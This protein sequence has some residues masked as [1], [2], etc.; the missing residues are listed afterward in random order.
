[1]MISKLPSQLLMVL[2]L[3]GF[4]LL[5]TAAPKAELW[6]IWDDSDEES[7]ESIDH[8]P[9]Q[10]LLQAYLISDHPSGVNRFDYAA[11]SDADSAR[12]EQYLDALQELDPRDYNRAEQ[13][14]YWINLYNALTVALILDEYPVKSILKVGEGVFNFFGPWDDV[15]AEVAGESLTLNDIEHRIL[16][17]IWQDSRI[18]FAVN[19]ASI[20]CPDL[21]PV[22][23]TA[24][25]SE[26]LLSQGAR[27]YLS[28]PRGAHF[29]AKQRLVLSEIF[30]WYGVDFGDSEQAVIAA[31]SQYAP[32]ELGEKMRRYNGKVIY[33]Y[34]W[35][36]NNP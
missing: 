20:G 13:Q 4:T 3:T 9:W 26:A 23:F 12:L 32:A 33:K 1:M 27:D 36:L 24:E 11:V 30:D 19:C 35:D 5:A 15:V 2:V 21:Q 31:I 25:N 8:G 16:R 10:Q 28:H 29:D 18:H 34:D 6:A 17:P 22:P 7:T 14:A